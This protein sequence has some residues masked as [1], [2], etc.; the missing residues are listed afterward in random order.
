MYIWEWR[1]LFE[2]WNEAKASS[3]SNFKIYADKMDG[4]RGEKV[5]DKGLTEES[6]KEKKTE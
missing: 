4:I 5:S 2:K 3:D 1:I 6:E